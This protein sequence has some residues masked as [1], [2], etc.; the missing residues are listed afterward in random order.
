MNILQ[1]IERLPD[2]LIYKIQRFLPLSIT[3]WITR[4]NY[5][6]N[7]KKIYI[8]KIIFDNYTRDM[9]RKNCW[10]VLKQLLEEN[11]KKWLKKKYKYKNI[12]YHNYIIF[13][14]AFCI[15]NHS[16]NCKNIISIFLEEHGISKNQHKNN[17]FINIK[18]KS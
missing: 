9:V 4:N 17:T 16:T 5:L 14:T 8:N 10:F 2:V 11:Y 18:W 7:H 13:L 1:R 15:E 12:I 3:V 6:N